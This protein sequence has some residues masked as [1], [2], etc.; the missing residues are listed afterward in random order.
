MNNVPPIGQS[1]GVSYALA[2]IISMKISEYCSLP[3]TMYGPIYGVVEAFV[4]DIPVNELWK[5]FNI[6]TVLIILVL[7]SI[8]KF[9]F[10]D[11]LKER[12]DIWMVKNTDD[13]LTLNI[14]THRDM[15]TFTKYVT[16]FNQF[17]KRALKYDYG[18]PQLLFNHFDAI[19]RTDLF[20]ISHL[21][22]PSDDTQIEFE[23]TNFNIKGIY[24]WKKEQ[25]NTLQGDK[26]IKVQVP[27]ISIKIEKNATNDVVTY[28]RNICKKMSEL[29][30][31]NTEQYYV[32]I[33]KKEKALTQNVCIIYSGQRLNDEKLEEMHIKPFFHKRKDE[34]WKTIKRINDNPESFYIRGQIPRFGGLLYGPPGT[35]K[36]SFAYRIAMALRRHIFTVDLLSINDRNE[37]FQIMRKPNI[38]GYYYTPKDIVYVFDEFDRTICTLLARK[39]KEKRYSSYS[40]DWWSSSR[41]CYD[42]RD[43]YNNIKS[44]LDQKKET[45]KSDK[46]TKQVKKTKKEKKTEGK[47][48]NSYKKNAKA[49]NTDTDVE[50][51]SEDSD[52]SDSEKE[53]GFYETTELTIED[54]QEIL[55]GPIPLE[56]AIIIATTNKYNEMREKCPALFRAGRLTPIEFGNADMW[57]INEVSKFYFKKDV[58]I[59]LPPKIKLQPS[60]IIET[61]L[62]QDGKPNG[63]EIFID[64]I[65][66]NTENTTIS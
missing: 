24:E 64:T 12:Y 50:E 30:R 9:A 26:D 16:H 59:V 36:S 61:A 15:D 25:I 39:E 42:P 1:Q 11:K 32:K 53:T 7:Y 8:R 66:K 52:S 17:Y 29:H 43:M 22:R 55:Q 37:I 56:G 46:K 3:S 19:R 40:S 35:G 47:M 31:N 62:M 34:L 27:Y 28:F 23:D 41:R 45:N 58:D 57:F 20:S 48:T 49:S 38:D 33:F 44:D 18:D 54:I 21:H 60:E 5:L 6:W 65:S 13:K 10:I 14:Y 63:Y 4:H 2:T 51:S